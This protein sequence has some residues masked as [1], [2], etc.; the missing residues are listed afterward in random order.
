MA[1]EAMDGS[2]RWWFEL[3]EAEGC[4]KGVGDSQIDEGKKAKRGAF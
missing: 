2:Q 1:R 3:V 4:A